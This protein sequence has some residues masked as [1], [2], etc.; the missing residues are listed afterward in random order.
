MKRS[1][2]T[3]SALFTCVA[4]FFLSALTVLFIMEFRF[5]KA[6]MADYEQSLHQLA[7][8]RTALFLENLCAQAEGAARQLARQPREGSITP[9]GPGTAGLSLAG[10][11]ILDPEAAPPTAK[12]AV[13]GVR[14][15]EAGRLVATV[16]TPFQG[17]WLAL[18]F[19]IGRARED[20]AREFLNGTCRVA[21][22]DPQRYPLLWPLPPEKLDHFTGQEARL[23]ADGVTYN[24]SWAEV[25]DPPW[26]IYFFQKENNFD[27]YR[28]ITVM[29]LLFA[30]YCCLYQFMVELW[31]VNSARSYF[32]HIDFTI[33]NYVNEGVIISNNAGKIIFANDAAH[34]I[35][36]GKKKSLQGVQVREIL[37]HRGENGEEKNNGPLTLK[38][39]DRTYSIVH[40][41]LVK[42]GRVLGAIT[43]IGP[44]EREARTCKNVLNRLME[45]APLAAIYVDEGFRVAAAN[46]LARCYLGSLEPG[47]SIDGVHPELANMLYRHAGARSAVPFELAGGLR[48]E[49]SYVYDAEGNYDGALVILTGREGASAPAHWPPAR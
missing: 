25:G 48:G 28:I 18:E 17:S 14:R 19:D 40:S 6:I 7:I 8:N 12:T 43:V 32:E 3:S 47:A 24:V 11:S 23:S 16:V 2:E 39:S 20:L 22:F 30:L 49:V 10:A 21:L 46:L 1:P 42:K 9:G 44:G 34:Q 26:R 38:I 15:D 36:A 29:L 13:T 37:G 45:V 35:F 41:P 4:F 5:S 33:F 31:R 27:A